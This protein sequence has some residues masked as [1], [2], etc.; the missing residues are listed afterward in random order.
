M[1][2]LTTDEFFI[3]KAI[4]WSLRQ[5]GKINEEW[6]VTFTEK[7]ELTPFAKMEALKLIK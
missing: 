2:D 3:Q 4:G 1:F 5:Y 6:V 7:I